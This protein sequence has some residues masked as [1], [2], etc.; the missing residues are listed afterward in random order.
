MKGSEE[1]EDSQ[2]IEKANERNNAS[3]TNVGLFLFFYHP[4]LTD[5][6][7]HLIRSQNISGKERKAF[8]AKS[9]FFSFI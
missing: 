1:S 7:D 4:R 3:A 9:T 2:K 8:F 6:S 5:L